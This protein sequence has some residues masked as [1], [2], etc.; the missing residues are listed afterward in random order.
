MKRLRRGHQ[1]RRAH[2]QCQIG[3][4]G[5][6]IK[7]LRAIQGGCE[8]SVDVT[9]Q[10]DPK[11]DLWFLYQEKNAHSGLLPRSKE[12]TEKDG[13]GVKRGC[14]TRP[15]VCSPSYENMMNTLVQQGK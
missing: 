15:L 4:D 1:D 9:V 8:F 14:T 13:H 11:L 12:I 6:E 10:L 2:K 5:F 7:D 3:C